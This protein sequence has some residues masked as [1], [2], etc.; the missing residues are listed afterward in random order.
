MDI[1][2]KK[3]DGYKTI[4]GMVILYVVGLIVAFYKGAGWQMPDW[5][6]GLESAATYTGASLGLV[7]IGD[8]FRKGELSIGGTTAVTSVGY[9]SSQDDTSKDTKG[10]ETES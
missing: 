2:I 8:K 4:I 1:I 7:G 10:S 9:P 5:L 6:A 3:I